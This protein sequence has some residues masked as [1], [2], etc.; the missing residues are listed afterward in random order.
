MLY[1]ASIPKSSL[2]RGEKKI[3]KPPAGIEFNGGE[4]EGGFTPVKKKEPP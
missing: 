3:L 4:C 2:H 1:H